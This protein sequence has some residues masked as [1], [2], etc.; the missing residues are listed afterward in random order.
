MQ[1]PCELPL[2]ELWMT[3]KHQ[4]WHP[5]CKVPSQQQELKYRKENGPPQFSCQTHRELEAEFE[6]CF[7]CV[8]LTWM[9]SCQ[10]C[11]LVS[12]FA[13]YHYWRTAK[14]SLQSDSSRLKEAQ[15]TDEQI[16]T[17]RLLRLF[18]SFVCELLKSSEFCRSVINMVLS[19]RKQ[20][21]ILEKKITNQEVI[22]WLKYWQ[23]I[24]IFYN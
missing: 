24:S 5:Q 6:S 21:F 12:Q 18:I 4:S 16:L 8:L 7:L 9:D 3:H 22:Q 11:L 10:K 20:I 17:F 13:H 23:R 1:P 15:K 2:G 14:P 19:V